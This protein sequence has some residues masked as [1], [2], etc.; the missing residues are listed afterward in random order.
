[1]WPKMIFLSSV[2]RVN[3]I[4]DDTGRSV[5][6]VCGAMTPMF[7]NIH[8]LCLF[9]GVLFKVIIPTRLGYMSTCCFVFPSLFSA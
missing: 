2:S 8:F 5:S 9:Q 3:Q 7:L 4:Q 6:S 1:M